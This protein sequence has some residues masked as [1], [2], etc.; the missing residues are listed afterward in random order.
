MFSTVIS[1]IQI[2]SAVTS[3]QNSTMADRRSYPPVTSDPFVQHLVSLGYDKSKL[4]RY[5]QCDTVMFHHLT[6]LAKHY[7]NLCKKKDK[8]IA[9]VEKERDE[10]YQVMIDTLR[11]YK[12]DHHE[13]DEFF[14]RPCWT[15]NPKTKKDKLL[16]PG[17]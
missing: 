8:Q 3:T 13:D 7:Y 9:K 16:S 14:H 15:V 17:E 6:D 1:N 11:K 4:E 12:P 5:C 10:M 2:P